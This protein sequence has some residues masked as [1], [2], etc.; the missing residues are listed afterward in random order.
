[1]AILMVGVFEAEAD[2]YRSIKGLEELGFKKKDISMISRNVDVLKDLSD[3][4]G[5][6]NPE[7]GPAS[8]G[9][10]GT[11]RTVVSGLDVLTEPVAAV[12]PVAQRAAGAGIGNGE[13]NSLAVA[14]S[15][16]G[17]PQEDARAY[18][19]QVEADR[20]LV[21]LE[22]D[23]EQQQEVEALFKETGALYI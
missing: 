18:E 5:T 12:G 11:L 19:S 20:F 4:A 2:L 1:M 23:E 7:T 22:C 17:I 16:L 21:M 13:E 9:L 10:L 15:G 8:T 6:K 3:I 14:L